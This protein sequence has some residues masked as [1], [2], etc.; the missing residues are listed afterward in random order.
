MRRSI[1][2]AGATA[3][4]LALSACGGNGGEEETTAAPAETA[5]AEE[6][7]AAEEGP[8]S[9][10]GQL[11]VWVDDDRQPY[12][13]EAAEAFTEETGV[14]V[15]LVIKN[16]EDIRADFA[17]QV[18]TGQGPD[19]TVGAHDWIGEFTANGIVSPIQLGDTAADYNPAA[20][21]AFTY[22]GQVY[23]V[24]YAV[25]NLGLIRNVELAPEPAPATFD[26]MIASGQEIGAE[27]PFMIQIGET[28]DPY[29]MYPF[30]TSFGAPVFL[31][32]A[33]GAYTA[34]LGMGGDEGRAFAQWLADQGAAGV[35][36]TAFTYDIVVDQF[37]SGN[38][39]Y[40]VGGPW[41]IADF[42]EAGVEVAVDPIPSAGG[43]EAIPFMGV[44][45][46]YLSAQSLNPLQATDFLV[47]YIGS[48]ETQLA[49]YQAGNRTPANIAAAEA[50]ADNPVSAGF[51]AIAEQALPMPA[52]PEMGSVWSFWGVTEAQIVSG[53][54]PVELW[55]K[56]ISDIEGAIAVG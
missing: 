37:S 29:T 31:Q 47:N 33:D 49:L 35:L 50:T 30:Q 19:I 45:G 24:P 26:E 9:V 17:A 6:T 51:A 12:V 41:M 22:N 23:G 15:E 1:L 10:E 55:D 13:Q 52:I 39:P 54:D 36:D 8:A 25:E 7:T 18:P 20:I 38:V 44:Q 32:D 14:P 27:F 16:N 48:E 3:V 2:L 56:M 28:G 4:A 43:S 42:T 53:G 21:R 34:E 5:T 46:F 11:V 40:I